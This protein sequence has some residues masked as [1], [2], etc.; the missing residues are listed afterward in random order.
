MMSFIW[1]LFPWKYKLLY[2][3]SYATKMI[4]LVT[5]RSVNNCFSPDVFSKQTN[6]SITQCGRIGK[7]SDGNAVLALIVTALGLFWWGAILFSWNES[8]VLKLWKAFDCKKKEIGR[9]FCDYQQC[10]RLFIMKPYQSWLFQ[11]TLAPFVFCQL[12]QYLHI[13]VKNKFKKM[14]A[15]LGEL[16]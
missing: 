1:T 7:I 8:M 2:N 16:K 9:Y 4:K 14:K 5:V 10:L 11:K 3:F 12:F 13:I 15:Y 6:T